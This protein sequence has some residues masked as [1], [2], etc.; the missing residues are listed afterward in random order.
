MFALEE[1]DDSFRKLDLSYQAGPG[2]LT[3]ALGLDRGHLYQLNHLTALPPF[4]L[5][6]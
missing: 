2:E 5:S 1:V 6:F 4:P 3:R